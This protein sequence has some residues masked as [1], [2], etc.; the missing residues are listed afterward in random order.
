MAE[1]LVYAV[2]NSAMWAEGLA[3]ER[4]FA[5]RA[6]PSL[7]QARGLEPKL[8]LLA[9][10]G[11]KLKATREGR[12]TFAHRFPHLF[13]AAEQNSIIG[14]EGAG[15]GFVPDERPTDR[16][17]GEIPRAFPTIHHQLRSIPDAEA[18]RVDVLLLTASASDLD[19]ETY[20]WQ[21]VTTQFLFQLPYV[22]ILTNLGGKDGRAFVYPIGPLGPVFVNLGAK[23]VHNSTTPDGPVLF[24]ELTHV[25][26]AKQ[27]VLT[28]IF[29]YDALKRE[30]DFTPGRQW[31]EYNLEQQSGIVQAWNS[32]RY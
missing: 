31:S 12:E 20:L 25:W 27:R 15:P 9:H 11:A 21:K 2:G 10:R 32:G 16:L 28:E 1:L 19:F 6:A 7:A 14:P 17:H 13:T 23:Y 4:K 5:V 29:L 26:Q 24:H 3:H 18:A 8:H 30:Y 22:S